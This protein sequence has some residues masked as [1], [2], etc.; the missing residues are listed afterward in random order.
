MRLKQLG[1]WRQ[2]EIAEAQFMVSHPNYSGFQQ[3]QL[4]QLWIPA[5]YV[6]RIELSLGGREILSF[7]GDI[8]ISANPTFRFF[9]K[10]QGSDVLHARVVDRSEEHT[11]ELQSQMRL[12][13]AVFCLKQIR[14]S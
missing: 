7:D 3:D 13:Y 5:H 10:P 9:V 6:R 12:S 11:S 1:S 8:S 2:N 4:T 14:I